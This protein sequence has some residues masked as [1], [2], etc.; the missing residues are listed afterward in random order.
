MRYR[1]SNCSSNSNWMPYNAFF[2]RFYCI[3]NFF[4]SLT[5]GGRRAEA[6]WDRLRAY[7]DRAVRDTSTFS[8]L[9]FC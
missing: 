9:N 8:N 1:A 7:A 4:I 6:G 5:L 2:L 3:L